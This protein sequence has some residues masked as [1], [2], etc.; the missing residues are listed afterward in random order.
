M[1]ALL[2]P[3]AA[4]A[5][6]CLAHL[7]VLLGIGFVIWRPFSPGALLAG[8]TSL[9]YTGYALVLVRTFSWFG[10]WPAAVVALLTLA[11]G[12]AGYWSERLGMRFVRPDQ[13]VVLGAFLGMILMSVLVGGH[14]G[15]L[16][17]VLGLVLG[18]FIASYGQAAGSPRLAWERGPIA[19]YSALGP[20]GFQLLLALAI[21]DLSTMYLFHR[22]GAVLPA[23]G[24][25]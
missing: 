3:D 7:G 8:L 22:V 12:T 4:L 6:F 15:I 23:V 1:A 14:G 19:L 20:R 16:T 21:G 9:A 5:A 10:L 2:S 25:P 17:L 13:R 24:L 11:A 18:A